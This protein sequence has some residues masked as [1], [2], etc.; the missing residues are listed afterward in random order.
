MQ[1]LAGF[2]AL[3]LFWISLSLTVGVWVGSVWLPP[4]WMCWALVGVCLA[5]A[6]FVGVFSKWKDKRR[7][8]VITLLSIAAVFL[9]VLRWR[10]VQ[11]DFTPKDLAWYNDQG[12]VSVVGV[13]AQDPDVRDSYVQVRVQVEQITL[14]AGGM[15]IGVEGLL[16]AYLPKGDWRYGDRL[17]ISG[18]LLTP[19]SAEDFSYRD[20][21]ARRDIF[22]YMPF[23]FA[24]RLE[25]GQGDPFKTWIYAFKQ[26]ALEKVYRY[27]PDPEASLVA[28][29]LL[30]V[31]SGIPEEVEIAFQ[32]TG[33]THIIAISG[34]NKKRLAIICKALPC[35]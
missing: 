10:A 23:A 6:V 8:V 2:T 13:V 4:A 24:D 5:L 33:T 20:Y 26:S 29:I 12:R 34:F 21:L 30:G 25:A 11:P 17:Y 18:E 22:S 35:Y 31:E 27:F 15:P 1:K 19:P 14:E 3:P 9:G 32:D 7:A 28:G 16:L